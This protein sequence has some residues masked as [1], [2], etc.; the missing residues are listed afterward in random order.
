LRGYYGSFAKCVKTVI[1]G[2]DQSIWAIDE[3]PARAVPSRFQASGGQSPFAF[4]CLTLK[5][6]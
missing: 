1:Y 4:S 3:L 2:Y 6:V 5:V